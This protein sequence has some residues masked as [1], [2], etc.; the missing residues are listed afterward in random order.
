MHT[1]GDL[2][3]IELGA[4]VLVLAIVARLARRSACP[5]FRCTC[6]WDL[7]SARAVSSSCPRRRSSSRWGAEIGVIL[8]LLMLGLEFSAHELIDNVRP[9]NAGR[10]RR[11]RPEFPAR[12]RGWTAAGVRPDRPPSC[13]VA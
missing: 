8:M 5:R 3:V 10:D 2:F 9:V 4:V 13:S 1:G 6:W 12:F 7:P 11:H